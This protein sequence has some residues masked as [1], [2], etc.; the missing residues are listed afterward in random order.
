MAT[1]R[2]PP[3]FLLFAA[4]FFGFLDFPS[5]IG[6]VKVLKRRINQGESMSVN[7]EAVDT[8]ANGSKSD[9]Q[10]QRSTKM[11]LA[12]LQSLKRDLDEGNNRQ[13]KMLSGI[14]QT[15]RR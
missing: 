12:L 10:G 5:C 1:V 2:A 7:A 6:A 4:L 3:V 9:D 14:Y 8:T 11:L 15:S 13:A